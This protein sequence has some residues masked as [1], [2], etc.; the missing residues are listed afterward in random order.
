MVC[1]KCHSELPD[2]TE[3]CPICGM[4]LVN[5]G[6][7]GY[8]ADPF[9][10][11]DD[12]YAP[13]DD[14]DAQC[15]LDEQSG[16]DAPEA[17]EQYTQP[18]PEPEPASGR[19]QRRRSYREDEPEQQ[20]Q[21]PEPSPQRPDFD[22]E[23]QRYEPYVVPA[24]EP[25]E[26]MLALTNFPS[27]L[28]AMIFEPKTTLNTMLDRADLWSGV[29]MVLAA[30]LMGLFACIGLGTGAGRVHPQTE[31]GFGYA[32]FIF[33]QYANVGTVIGGGLIALIVGTLVT[34][35]YLTLVARVPLSLTLVTTTM[36]Y[37]SLPALVTSLPILVA[38]MFSPLLGYA[39]AAGGFV[40][41]QHNLR[42]VMLETPMQTGD[43]TA[44]WRSTLATMLTTLLTVMLI[45]AFGG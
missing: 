6:Y 31:S 37:A 38:S 21:E 16:E 14:P 17:Y 30:L 2:G 19:R 43:D 10:A 18:E 41:A 25:G 40:W 1:R 35:A 32:L 20:E 7:A 13:Y 4:P 24:E 22:K 34:A 5:V 8:A 29:L 28:R 36:A 33:L 12:P 23:P 26:M 39:L 42:L 15:A 27:F 45:A 3:R 44:Q 11:Y 9:A